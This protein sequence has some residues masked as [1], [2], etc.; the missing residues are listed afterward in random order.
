M[1]MQWRGSLGRDEQGNRIE[2]LLGPPWW[3]RHEYLEALRHPGTV[4]DRGYRQRLCRNNPLI[5][6]LI[7]FAGSWLLSPRGTV[8]LN[9]LQC[10]MCRVANR[11]GR[12]TRAGE[13]RYGILGPRGS[14]KSQWAQIIAL[15]A[16]IFGHRQFVAFFGMASSHIR[17]T[18]FASM[19]EQIHNN[20]L[21]QHDYPNFCSPATGPGTDTVSQYISRTGATLIARGVDEANLGLNIRGSRPDLVIL[22]DIQGDAGNFT[23][24]QKQKRLRTVRQGILG[25]DGAVRMAVLYLGTTVAWGCIT[26]DLVRAAVAEYEAEW[27]A[28]T[29]FKSAYYPAIIEDDGEM[30]SLWPVAWSLEELLELRGTLDFELNKMNRPM[31]AGG[32]MWQPH[33][34]VYDVPKSWMYS[35]YVCWVDPAVTN[36]TT[37]DYT[38]IA[39]AGYAEHVRSV[40]VL[41]SG[42]DRYTPDQF[43]EHMDTVLTRFYPRGLREIKVENNQGGDY[44]AHTLGP[45]KRKYPGLHVATPNT[46]HDKAY[47]FGTAFTHYERGKVRHAQQFRVAEDQMLRFNQ[48]SGPKNDDAADAVV[49]AVCELLATAN[50]ALTVR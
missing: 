27:V 5:F 10:D 37:S 44:V 50:P 2:P 30:R 8:E 33:H 4:A 20:K 11:F 31:A 49:R 47:Y 43:T 46:S 15:W 18:H 13:H 45:L 1:V 9:D 40:A 24:E 7:Y 41:S 17:D 3:P 29:G 6:G 12:P 19:R 48:G 39:V 21:L 26:H 23:D 32:T 22:D 25:M 42:H 35:R 38:G 16:T 34:F 36:K 14:G 28:E